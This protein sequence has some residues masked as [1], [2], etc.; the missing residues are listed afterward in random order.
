MNENLLIHALIISD[1]QGR[2]LVDLIRNKKLDTAQL[3]G[4][5]A[6]FKMFGEETLG[7]IKAISIEGLDIDMLVVSKYNLIFIAIM[8]AYC[9]KITDFR[10]GCQKAL[11]AF[12]RGYKEKIDDWDGDLRQF[13]EFRG[14]L[15]EQVQ[16]YLSKLK[17]FKQNATGSLN[18]R[19][20]SKKRGD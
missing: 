12:Y 13:R 16:K 18:K 20:F 7:N 2:F 14:I 17:E 15:K 1:S 3:S 8:N 10:K 6:A 11:E 4:F 19:R 5:I 9:S